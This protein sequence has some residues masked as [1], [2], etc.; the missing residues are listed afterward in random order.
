MEDVRLE[1]P[2]SPAGIA[3]CEGDLALVMSGGGARA[4]YQVGLL[5]VLARRHPE[6]EIPILTGVSAGAINAVFLAAHSGRLALRVE[7]LVE[8]W[9]RLGVRDVFRVGPLGLFTQVAWWGGSLLSGGRWHSARRGMVDTAPLRGFLRDVLDAPQDT[10]AGVGSRIARGELRALAITASS[11]TT[12]KS[13]TWIQGCEM[14]TWER[15]GRRSRPAEITVGHVLASSALPLLFPAVKVENEWFGDGGI[16][17]TAPLSPAV[18]LG[19]RK[20][21]AISTRY[22]RTRAEADDPAVVGYPPPAQVAGV[23]LNAIFLD[24]FD[25]DA[26]RLELTNRLL[27]RLPGEQREGLRTLQLCVLR[28]SRDLGRLANEYEAELPRTFRFLTRGLG[29]RRTRSNDLLSLVMFQNDYLKALLELGERDG[30]TRAA[31]IDRF[32]AAPLPG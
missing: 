18:H 4:A 15:P 8:I 5:R 29:T 14:P 27:E 20:I 10:I 25:G 3:R 9:N 12:G 19:A 22:G 1:S 28:P 30:E 26:L 13:I 17:L 24:Q 7:R 6:L 31:E 21:L 11:Y 2:A 23:L 32:L 16:R